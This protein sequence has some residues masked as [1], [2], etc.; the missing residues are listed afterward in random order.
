VSSCR[1]HA[2][3]QIRTIRSTPT[4]TKFEQKKFVDVTSTVTVL[5]VV[6]LVLVLGST[7]SLVVIL[8]LLV[9][10]YCWYR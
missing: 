9:C 2:D 8:S 4:S 5:S 7:G 10:M 1:G 3:S 6:W